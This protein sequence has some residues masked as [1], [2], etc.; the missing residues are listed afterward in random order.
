MCPTM[1]AGVDMHRLIFTNYQKIELEAYTSSLPWARPDGIAAHPAPE[2]H[3]TEL[4]GKAAQT[5]R[6]KE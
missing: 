6:E 2:T 3:N 5:N 1:A 4:H